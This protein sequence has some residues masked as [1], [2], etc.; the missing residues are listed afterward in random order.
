MILRKLINTR[1]TISCIWGKKM[2]EGNKSEILSKELKVASEIYRCNF[3]TKEKIWFNKLVKLMNEKINM[4]KSTVM[5]AL[6]VLFDWGIVRGEYG[7]TDEGRAGRLL[8]ITSEHKETIKK[9][10]EKYWKEEN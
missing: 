1:G 8:M 4:S 5:N 10:Y 6:N 7:E 3:E 9:V 2:P